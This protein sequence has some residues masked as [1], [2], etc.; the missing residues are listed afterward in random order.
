MFVKL[1]INLLNI[2]VHLMKYLIIFP[3][4]SIKQSTSLLVYSTGS[5]ST[6]RFPGTTP[7]SH[8]DADSKMVQTKP[9]SNHHRCRNGNEHTNKFWMRWW[10]VRRGLK[11][12]QQAS[13]PAAVLLDECLLKFQELYQQNNTL[14]GA[15]LSSHPYPTCSHHHPPIAVVHTVLWNLKFDLVA[16]GWRMGKLFHNCALAY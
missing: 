1:W 15:W 6:L 13:Q 8:A 14:P 3:E 16:I 7:R 12:M 10:I 11:S 5:S 9:G 4:I 2:E